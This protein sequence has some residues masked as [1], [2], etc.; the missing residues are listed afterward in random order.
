MEAV[1]L[2][3]FELNHSI[4]ESSY[5]LISDLLLPGRLMILSLVTSERII[6]RPGKRRSLIK[7]YELSEMLWFN[8]NMTRRTASIHRVK[9]AHP[10][11]GQL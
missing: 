10:E 1:L 9:E 4:S 8:S 6:S 3:I 11:R 5:T 7:V 2:V